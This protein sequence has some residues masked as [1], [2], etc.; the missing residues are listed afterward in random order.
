[1]VTSNIEKLLHIRQFGGESVIRQA[2]EKY[3]AV[4]LLG[5]PVIQQ[6]Q[7]AAVALAAN[8]PSKSLFQG[9]GRL[10]NLVVVKRIAPG[11]ADIFDSGIHH[12]IVGH[13]KGQFIY[14]N[15][16]QLFTRDIHALPEG[17]SREKHA[18]GSGAELLQQRVARARALHQGGV[19]DFEGHLL[20]HQAHLL[21]AGEEDESAPAAVFQDLD[22]FLGGHLGEGGIL[23]FRQLL[24][25]IEQRLLLVIEVAG[26][27]Q[28]A[29]VLQTEALFRELETA[30]H[31]ER[32]AGEH[33]GIHL[34]E[35]AFGNDAGHVDGGG[36]EEAAAAALFHPVDEIRVVLLLEEAQSLVQFLG[37]AKKR[38]DLLRR[39]LQQPEVGTD[40][41]ERGQQVRVNLL[42]VLAE[43]VTAGEGDAPVSLAKEAEKLRGEFVETLQDAVQFRRAELLHPADEAEIAAQVLDAVIADPDAEIL[44]HHVFDF[45]GFV[46]HHGMIR[47]QDAALVVLI[48]QGEIGEEQVVVDDDDV[49]FERALVQQGDEAAVVV[50][51]FLAAAQF[52]AGI[53]LG[54]PRSGLGE[55]VYF[56]AVAEL[57]DLFPFAHD[58]EIGDFLQ[59]RSEEHTYELQSR[60][61][62]VCRL[63]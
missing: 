35:Q 2:V 56:G 7:H 5:D 10:R 59:S 23:R 33:H 57:A 31:G 9:D 58:L 52:G 6:D 34:A 13:R 44:A 61:Y 17:G 45:V 40:Q 27:Y 29:R 46:E 11:F 41:F 54:P 51:S 62:L 42:I 37:A 14:D 8:Q 22:H 26:H 50:G 36:L 19:I 48:L 38:D 49:A 24:G 60:Q 32:G 39:I 43:G 12:R 16:A 18:I 20:V 55:L 3:L 53:P 4:S 28:G 30:R 25:H 47:G 21:I 1:M 15:A 63:L